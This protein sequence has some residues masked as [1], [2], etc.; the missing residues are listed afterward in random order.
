MT[1]ENQD[2]IYSDN[3]KVKTRSKRKKNSR[4]VKIYLS[5]MTVVLLA[6]VF[7]V[8]YSALLN[9]SKIVIYESKIAKSEEL[10]R[11]AELK[12][13]RLKDEL[14]NF[15]S[16]QKVESI[17]RNNLK[18]A[19]DNEVLVIINSPKED[20]RPKTKKEKVIE[21]FEKNIASKFVQGE[22]QNGLDVP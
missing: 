13:Q 21:F 8:A 11:S 17:A 19:E 5:F 18:M 6:C 22:N 20:I 9:I 1:L 3:L 15:N 7:Q 12:N 14:E 2:T 4:H 10:K 16:I